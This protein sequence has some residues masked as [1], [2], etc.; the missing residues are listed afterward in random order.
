MNLPYIHSHDI[1]LRL[2]VALLKKI[3]QRARANF[4]TRSD[5]IRSAVV[6]RI[7]YEQANEK[8]R[9]PKEIDQ[10]SAPSKSLSRAEQEEL[11]KRYGIF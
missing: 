8:A 1:H 10:P 9:Q 6:A 2:S 11:L 7:S 5:Y 4:T 3:D